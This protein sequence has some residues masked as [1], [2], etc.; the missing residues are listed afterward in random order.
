MRLESE[1]YLYDIARAADLIR[2]FTKGEAFAEGLFRLDMALPRG[3]VR[4]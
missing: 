4:A 3:R 1:K 2:R